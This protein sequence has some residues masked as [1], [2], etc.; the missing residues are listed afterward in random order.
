MK[1]QKHGEL[2]PVVYWNHVRQPKL[3]APGMDLFVSWVFSCL[4]NSSPTIIMLGCKPGNLTDFQS[5]LCFDMLQLECGIKGNLNSRHLQ[6]FS[7]VPEFQTTEDP[8]PPALVRGCCGCWHKELPQWQLQH[9]K[10]CTPLRNMSG[11][12]ME[13]ETIFFWN[14]WTSFF[15]IA[16][17]SIV[18]WPKQKHQPVIP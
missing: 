4:K 12:F 3:E 16:H 7:K 11:R 18:Q 14:L 17:H 6:L 13:A 10:T 9:T 2:T 1:P 5:T 15:I 8:I